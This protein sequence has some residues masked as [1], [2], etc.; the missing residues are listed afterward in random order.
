MATPPP[1]PMRSPALDAANGWLHREIVNFLESLRRWLGRTSQELGSV[2]ETAQ[3]AAIATTDIPTSTLQEGLYRASYS[4]RITRAATTS[5]SAGMTFGW[6]T[7]GVSVT[8]TFTAV[9][10]NTTASQTSGSITIQVD[11]A[12]PVTYAISYASVG[13]TSMQYAFN[14][15]LEELP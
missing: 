6:T 8:Q 4:L 5:S 11:A 2:A 3:G 15:R 1:V 14:V 10:G 7:N 13:A 12:T 9:T